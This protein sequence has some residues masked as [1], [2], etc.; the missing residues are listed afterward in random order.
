MKIGLIDLDTSHPETWIPEIRLLGH[1]VACVLDH[2]DVHPAGY[3]QKF[4]EE[5]NI[6]C[7]STDLHSMVE[8]VDLAIIHSCNWDRHIPLAT[9]FLDAN[10]AVLIDKPLAGCVKD[11]QQLTQWSSKG[12]RITGGSALRFCSEIHA[13]LAQPIEERGEV[14]TAICGC[15]VDVFNY[16]I[17]AYAMLAAILGDDAISVRH[18]H[19]GS[20]RHIEIQFADE[21]YGLVM[22]GTTTPWLPFHCTMITDRKVAQIPIDNQKLYRSFLETTLPYLAG[23]TTQPPL[24]ME[25]LIQPE[26][27]ALAAQMSWMQGGRE[28]MLHELNHDT[29]GYDGEAFCQSYRLTRYPQ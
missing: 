18:I 14:S 29:P 3:A 9:P 21:R 20:L 11:L 8:Q 23:E 27:W 7:V 22:V 24:S 5:H 12:A 13:W 28:V 10:R 16:G 25:Q 2:G 26:R 15:G 6:P 4:A 17:H 19:E 1:E